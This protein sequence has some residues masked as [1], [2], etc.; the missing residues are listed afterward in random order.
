MKRWVLG[1]GSL[2]LLACAG[3]F[4]YQ[5]TGLAAELPPN[6]EQLDPLVQDLL[7]REVSR[8]NARR[9]S[10]PAWTRL[11]Q[12][13][14]ANGLYGEAEF[15]YGRALELKPHDARSFHRLACVQERLGDLERAV[16]T[17][18][19]AAE[20]EPG[21]AGSWWTLAGWQI[22]L[23]DLEGAEVSL[24][25]AEELAPGLPAVQ[26]AR[27]RWEL[28]RGEPGRAVERLQQSDLLDAE[29]PL[30]FAYHLLAIALRQGGDSAGAEAAQE[31]AKG[32][33]PTFPHAWLQ[34]MQRWQTGYAALRTQAG[35][36]VAQ[37]RLQDAREGLE[38]ILAYDPDDVRS[39]N[40]LAG[41]L[42]E[43]GDHPAALQLLAATAA[44]HPEHRGTTLNWA[45]TLLRSQAPDREVLEPVRRALIQLTERDAGDAEAWRS[46][47]RVQEALGED[48]G[49]LMSLDR[50]AG[51][52]P[53]E[54][55]IP[56]KA[57]YVAMKL[58][59][60]GEALERFEQVVQVHGDLPQAALGEFQAL[61][62]D[63]QRAAAVQALERLA[64]R[65]DVDPGQLDQLRAWWAS[66]P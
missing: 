54:P 2:L 8:L 56:L 48:Q 29:R 65:P 24:S 43:E 15:A 64:D 41:C 55:E 5:R 46:L 19:L 34:E 6:L 27:V 40:M 1:L 17:M 26:V 42:L 12:V 16:E 51:L 53:E 13:L 36:L 28:A 31:R 32:L 3:W 60:H 57:A 30:P 39:A 52:L 18:E 61:A 59:H 14:E 7:R 47:A 35:R 9:R 20:F 23:G 10:G 58:G 49:S 45:E 11:G 4:F 37:G 33:R 44:K 25:K 66:Q 50:A 22:D 38:R 21:Y 62:L 63:G